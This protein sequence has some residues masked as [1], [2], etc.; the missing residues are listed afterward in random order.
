MSAT[1]D[2]TLADPEQLIA[3]LRRQLAE[4]KTERDEALQRETATAEVLGVINSSPGDLAP[5]FDALLKKAH[6]LCGVEQGGLVTYDGEHFRMVADHGV[7]DWFAEQLRRPFRAGAGSSHE[8]L[9]RGERLVHIP[10]VQAA[11]TTPQNRAAI[12]QALARSY[13]CHC[14]RMASCLA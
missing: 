1:S 4:C 8:K 13:W 9:L 7:P 3:D 11:P 12:R 10:D 14:V 6:A 2:D 5:V